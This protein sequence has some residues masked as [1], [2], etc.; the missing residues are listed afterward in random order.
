MS[1][2]DLI[3]REEFNRLTVRSDTRAIAMTAGNFLLLAAG[4]APPILWPYWPVWCV[5]AVLLGGR[6]LALGILVHDTAHLALFSSEK[7]NRWAG[8]WL[9]G[10]LPNVGYEAY[11]KGHL[12]H[13]R[14]AGTAADPDLVFVNA[15]PAST[16]SLARKLLRDAS[17][18]NGLKNVLYQIRTFKLADHAPF[19]VAHALLFGVLWL[20]GHPAVYLCWWLGYIFVFPV[21]LRIRV[22]GEHGGVPDHLDP[23]PRA[24]TGTTLAG[25]ISRL[26][27]AP[28]YVNFHVE[29]H[30]APGVPSYR[31]KELHRLMMAKGH[32]QGWHCIQKSYVGVIKRCWSGQAS[33]PRRKGERRAHGALN[34]MQ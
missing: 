12:T 19:L 34:N 7:V 20:I 33:G 15:F 1:I 22:M 26:L 27:W 30:L 11:R 3:D 28:N 18:L 6:A 9:F 21:V 29:H 16:G 2:L 17:G 23:D 31:L 13:H 5:A 10:A 8:K 32:Y 14:Y 25:P 24:H 4:F